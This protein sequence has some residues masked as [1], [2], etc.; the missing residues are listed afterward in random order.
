[1]KTIQLIGAVIV[2]VLLTCVLVFNFPTD[3]EEL[4]SVNIGNEYHYTQLTGTISTTTVIKTGYGTLGAVVITE[5]QAGAVVLWDATSSAAVTDGT[6]ATRVA[7]FQTAS[8]EGTYTFDAY[9]TKGLVLVSDDG[10][11]FDGDWTL[12]WR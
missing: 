10:F 9:L 3:V 7:D 11:V 4:G 2:G 6:F 8:T 1:M 5:D 12:L